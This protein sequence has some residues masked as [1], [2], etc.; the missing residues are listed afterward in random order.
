MVKTWLQFSCYGLR[1]GWVNFMKIFNFIPP[2]THFRGLISILFFIQVFDQ[3]VFILSYLL[4]LGR[5]TPDIS[6][7]SRENKKFNKFL[8]FSKVMLMKF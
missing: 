4:V 5:H 8:L 1:C 2:I 7:G 3:S 6:P